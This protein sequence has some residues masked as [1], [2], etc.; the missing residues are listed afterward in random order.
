M[1]F[2]QANFSEVPP[3]PSIE[4]FPDFGVRHSTSGALSLGV[5]RK[6]EA[7]QKK[8]KK[9]GWGTD[10]AGSRKETEKQQGKEG[11][12]VLSSPAPT[13]IT[14]VLADYPNRVFSDNER[15]DPGVPLDVGSPNSSGH[16]H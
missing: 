9:I 7:N 3:T 6:T 4:Y 16:S 5:G 14:E 12:V 13:A 11:C 15:L 10:G 2:L 1:F 8:K